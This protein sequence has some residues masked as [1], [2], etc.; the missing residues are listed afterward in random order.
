MRRAAGVTSGI[1]PEVD[2]GDRTLA[3]G[4]VTEF[5]GGCTTDVV[6]KVTSAFAAFTTVTPELSGYS[7]RKKCLVQY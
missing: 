7:Y 2:G 3:A 6:G 5:E 1:T 4:V